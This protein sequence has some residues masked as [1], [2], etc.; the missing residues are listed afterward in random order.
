LNALLPRG[1]ADVYQANQKAACD[2]SRHPE[3]RHWV[4]LNPLQKG[5]YIQAESLLR[6][7]LCVGIKIH[8]EEHG[9]AIREYGQELFEFAE[10]YQAVILTHS[11]EQHSL[12]SDY[13]PLVNQ[14]S[15]VRLILAHLGC[16]HDGDPTHQIRAIRQAK[17]RNMY[18]DTSS[19]MNITSGLLE[20]AVEQIGED[21]IL[22]GTDSP[23]YSAS[24]HR[25]RIDHAE[26]T[27]DQK[28]RILLHNANE[29]FQLWKEEQ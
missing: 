13:V 21:R 4:V 1:Q 14:Y 5:T 12:P 22:F 6:H 27:E 7:P 18:V 23:L 3:L 20:W 29:L 11:G 9:Y 17:H 8:P 25:A 24:A 16:G 15:E 2:I 19:A 28:K 10:A 26:I